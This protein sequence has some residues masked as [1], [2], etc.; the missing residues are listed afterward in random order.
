M[1]H[2]S[3]RSLTL[4]F[5]LIFFKNMEMTG[6]NFWIFCWLVLAH[7]FLSPHFGS[8]HPCSL[9]LPVIC[10][11]LVK[12]SVL[13]LQVCTLPNTAGPQLTTSSLLLKQLLTTAACPLSSGLS[14]CLS[15]SHFAV[16]L[17]TGLVSALQNLF[18]FS[19]PF[20]PGCYSSAEA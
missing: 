3:K 17:E 5:A 12:E 13:L 20:P 14:A 4:W 9:A 1:L 19:S 11:L 18:F 16:N 10:E 2:T 6:Y 8:T 15:K 7:H